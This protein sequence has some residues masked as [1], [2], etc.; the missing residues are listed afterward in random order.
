[1]PSPT[2][3]PHPCTAIATPVP[4]LDRR[5]EVQTVPGLLEAAP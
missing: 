5:V 2:L 4:R 1:M 3:P